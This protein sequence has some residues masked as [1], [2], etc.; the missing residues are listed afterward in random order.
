[1]KQNLEKNIFIKRIIDYTQCLN[2]KIISKSKNTK[3]LKENNLSINK[4]KN[5]YIKPHPIFIISN[6]YKKNQF[7]LY[8][9][10]QKDE[11]NIFIKSNNTERHEYLDIKRKLKQILKKRK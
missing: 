7:Y 1:M 11:N 10:L 6:T 3:E 2:P 8:T 5:Y 4:S 9:N